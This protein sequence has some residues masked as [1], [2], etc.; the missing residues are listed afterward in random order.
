MNNKM[1]VDV[2]RSCLLWERGP[3][4]TPVIVFNCKPRRRYTEALE[5]LA[6]VECDV[7]LMELKY[8]LEETKLDVAR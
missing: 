8:I 7:E 6:S 4:Q 2:K 1:T 3:S 5:E